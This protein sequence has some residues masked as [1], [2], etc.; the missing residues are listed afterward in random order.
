MA[1][2][3]TIAR[4]RLRLAPIFEDQ[5]ITE[6]WSKRLRGH[7]PRVGQL[8]TGVRS[9]GKYLLIDIENGLTL[10]TH[11]GM[12][13]SWRAYEDSVLYP[14]AKVRSSPYLRVVLATDLGYALCSKA[15]KVESFVRS[16]QITPVS[17][18][19]PDLCV[20]G[21]D[22][23]NVVKRIRQLPKDTLLV[24][25]LLDQKIACGIGN[26]FKSEVLFSEKLAP[27]KTIDQLNDDQLKSLFTKA[28]GMLQENSRHGNQVR[29]T[30]PDG[31]FFVYKR[32]RLPCKV[33]GTVISRSY[34]GEFSRSTYWC[35]TCQI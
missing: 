11:L 13:G 1:E 18:L 15:S 23:D 27:F 17:G 12:N 19:G 24:E 5:V 3:D 4:A 14:E 21:F 25:S 33:C 34:K 6:F 30:K 28:A 9:V 32:W 22:I 20:E 35:S 2:G 7:K 29:K 8:I 26:I 16:S 31:G 10:S